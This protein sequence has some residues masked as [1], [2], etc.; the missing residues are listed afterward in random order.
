MYGIMTRD[1]HRLSGF[2]KISIDK[3]FRAPRAQQLMNPR[4]KNMHEGLGGMEWPLASILKLGSRIIS[5][6]L[7]QKVSREASTHGL[8]TNLTRQEIYASVIF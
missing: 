1:L 3:W 6:V 4:N 8:M 7:N 2:L 5:N